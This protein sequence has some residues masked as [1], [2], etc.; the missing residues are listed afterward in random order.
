MIPMTQAAF[1]HQFRR[2]ARPIGLAVLLT[3]GLLVTSPAEAQSNRAAAQALFEEG[4]DLM[5]KGDY[6]AACPKLAESQR[7]DPGVGTQFNLASCYEKQGKLAS[8]WTLYLEVATAT[9]KAGELKREKVARESADALKPKLTK[10]S[11]KVPEEA[12]IEGLEV[13]MG[14]TRVG[15]A[16][17]GVATPVDP[18]EV[19]VSAKAPGKK[20]WRETVK[21]E[22][23]GQTVEVE[24]PVL[25]D[26]PVAGSPSDSGA[27]GDAISVSGESATGGVPPLRMASYVA[28]GV[29][30]V[31]VGAGI[32]FLVDANAQY[33]EADDLCT[34]NGFQCPNDPAVLARVAELDSSGDTSSTLSIVSFVVGG[35]A[36]G[37]GV[38]MF[39][40]SAEDS[41][42]QAGVHPW[43]GP[44]SIGV[45]GR[46]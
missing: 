11:I 14:E 40:L 37:A 4:R 34:V 13:H 12:R 24:V 10:L 21:A 8:A 20:E 38:S 35:V 18:G 1:S 27:E 33:G 25:E 3:A 41:S 29:G 43:V 7:L 44:G 23:E 17:W 6:D 2:C 28:F 30:A 45:R 39:V 5:K 36:L 22:G 42:N 31:G 15:T 16:L 26:A 19:E 46:F 32:Y 9:R